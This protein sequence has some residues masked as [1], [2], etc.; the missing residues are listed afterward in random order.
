MKSLLIHLTQR[1]ASY[2]DGEFVPCTLKQ[3]EE[4]EAD[5]TLTVQRIFEI[6]ALERAAMGPGYLELQALAERVRRVTATG[7]II[8]FG[9]FFGRTTAAIACTKSPQQELLT[10]DN[11]GWNPLG[12]TPEQHYQL[13]EKLLAGMVAELKTKII[14]MERKKFFSVYDGGAP[15]LVYV[16]SEHLVEEIGA[17]IE[18]AQKL[19][20][21]FICGTG[22]DAERNPSLVHAIDQRGSV[23]ECTGTFWVLD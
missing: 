10:V 19:G 14:W 17:T 1:L 4:L 2:L 21:E 23:G 20:A 12:F 13:I 22:Y 6:G 3:Q 16:S 5:P 9:T 8:E 18:W 7:P 15:S 11:Y